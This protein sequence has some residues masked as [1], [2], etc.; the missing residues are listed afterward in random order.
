MKHVSCFLGRLQNSVL[1]ASSRN[2]SK[3]W[4]VGW[5]S[6]CAVNNGCILPKTLA[7][8]LP[9]PYIKIF[10]GEV[11]SQTTAEQEDLRGRHVFSW[12]LR[13]F[14]CLFRIFMELGESGYVSLWNFFWNLSH[15][16]KNSQ[17][18]LNLSFQQLSLHANVNF[19]WVPPDNPSALT[20]P[21]IQSVSLQT[22]FL[23]VSM[24]KT[25]RNGPIVQTIL[26]QNWAPTQNLFY[27][28]LLHYIRWLCM[29]DITPEIT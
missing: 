10:L 16:K 12:I 27:L 4:G 26:G 21:V 11:T 25:W 24:A 18:T 22:E 15:W 8:V 2:S 7:T 13:P 29:E 23:G 28:R 19:C 20:L 6:V 5:Q 14:P 17:K 1:A 9:P 3:H